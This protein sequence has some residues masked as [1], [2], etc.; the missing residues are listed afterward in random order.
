MVSLLGRDDGSIRGQDKVDTRVRDEIGLELGQIDIEGTIKAERSSEGRND[1]SNETV[2]VGVGRALNV[3]VATANIIDGLIVDE[4]LN[5][6][7]LEEGVGAE[8]GVIGLN[9]GGGDLRRGIDGETELRLLAVV[10]GEALQE[11]GTEAGASA[12]T[13]GVE[14]EEALETRA[15]V[16]ELADAVEA[17]VDDF[18][19]D[20]V[21]ATSVVVGGILLAGDQLLRVEELA[22]GARA[23]LVDDGGL[24][25]EE[26]AAGH[27]LAGTSL[28]EESVESIITST[29][30]LITGHLTIR[31][32][33]MLQTVELPTSITDLDTCLTDVNGNNLTHID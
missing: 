13:D 3:E 18:L 33:T 8:N 15:V 2:E 21:V 16:G 14:H 1:L 17:Q 32:D 22:V 24:K 26:H 9:D 28:R 12:T 25:V 27:V 30:G 7:V 11:E 19:A 5:V 23:D 6:S 29:D 31:L 4:E 20:R 10:D